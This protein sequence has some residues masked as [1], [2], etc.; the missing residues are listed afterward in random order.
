[1]K[2]IIILITTI[3]FSCKTSKIPSIIVFEA[4]SYN[5]KQSIEHY[6]SYKYKFHSLLRKDSIFTVIMTRNKKFKHE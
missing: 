6:E 5:L 2:L 4:Q 1:M 3:L